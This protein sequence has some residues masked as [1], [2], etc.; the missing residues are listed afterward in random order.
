MR[1]FKLYVSTISGML[2]SLA[3]SVNADVDNIGKLEFQKNCAVCHGADGKGNGQILDVLKQ[4]PPDLTLITN[5][6][7]GRYPYKQIYKWIEDPTGIRAHGSQEMPIWGE[8]YSKEVIN[9]YGPFDTRH[10]GEVQARILELVFYLA[11]I[12]Q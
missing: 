8:R 11:N 6:H 2:L 7:G 12:Q 9:K 3:G 5:R 1:L 10:P 4:A